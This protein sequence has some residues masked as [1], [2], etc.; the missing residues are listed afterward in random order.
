MIELTVD[1]H[2][3]NV[4]IAQWLEHLPRHRR[5]H[6]VRTALR[7]EFFSGKYLQRLYKVYIF[8]EMSEKSMVCVNQKFNDVNVFLN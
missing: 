4:F 1:M 8:P 7:P 2:T 3:T 5:G 6:W